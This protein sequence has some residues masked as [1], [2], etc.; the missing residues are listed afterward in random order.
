MEPIG[1]ETAREGE[2]LQQ[3]MTPFWTMNSERDGTAF[4]PWV[5]VSP[6]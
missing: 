1:G 4:G 5:F 2:F 6:V 3:K